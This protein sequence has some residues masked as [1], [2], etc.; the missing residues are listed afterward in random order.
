MSDFASAY[1]RIS[2]PPAWAARNDPECASFERHGGV[3]SLQISAARKAGLVTDDDLRDFANDHLR[4][5]AKT[6]D[7]QLGDFSGFVLRYRDEEN[8]WRQ[9]FLRCGATAVFVAYNCPL[10]SE[11]EEDEI[12]D[13]VLGTLRAQQIAL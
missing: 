12:V 10:E 1:W 7:L 3:G 5:G 6:K 8:Y 11:G 13:S 2:V 4:A 9:W